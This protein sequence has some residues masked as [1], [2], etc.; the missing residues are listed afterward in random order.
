M[1]IER[2]RRSIKGGQS[3]LFFLSVVHPPESV[4]AGHNLQPGFRS[5]P[6]HVWNPPANG[7]HRGAPHHLAGAEQRHPPRPQN[8]DHYM[9]QQHKKAATS[10]HAAKPAAHK[11]PKHAANLS[12]FN[13]LFPPTHHAAHAGS[14]RPRAH[15]AP[16]RMTSRPDTHRSARPVAHGHAAS[17][18]HGGHHP[19]GRPRSPSPHSPKS[20]SSPNPAPK[21]HGKGG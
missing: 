3:S 18:S 2:A 8:H 11:D 14:G 19:P 17:S 12:K 16:A 5:A 9:Q 4:F 7:P 13:A 15:E 20:H 6:G 1:D 21:K 10:H